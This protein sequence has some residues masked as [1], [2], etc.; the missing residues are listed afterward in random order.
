M[1]SVT[2]SGFFRDMLSD[3]KPST[4]AKDPLPLTE[5]SEDWD[6]V[7]LVITGRM[8]ELDYRHNSWTQAARLYQIARKYQLDS[9]RPWFTDICNFW[10]HE[11]PIDALVLACNGPEIDLRM[12]QH[13]IESLWR[14]N[15]DD[16]YY[17]N[18]Q[19]FRSASFRSPTAMLYPFATSSDLKRAL[20]DASNVSLRFGIALGYKA[21][22]AYHQAFASLAAGPW[23]KPETAHEW[24]CVAIR[25]LNAVHDVEIELK[26]RT[27]SVCA[28]DVECLKAACR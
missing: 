24:Q 3:S 28:N 7:L 25:F 21:S 19:F 15:P 9:H 13:A 18:P 22:L 17:G 11:S 8:N 27:V 23:G 1:L 26:G 2:S 10:L 6:I 20:L 4:S 16:L 5:N 14:V 12:S